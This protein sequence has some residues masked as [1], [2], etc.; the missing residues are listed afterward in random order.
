M[1]LA[2]VELYYTV[3]SLEVVSQKPTLCPFLKITQYCVGFADR[4]QLIATLYGG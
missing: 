1:I 4:I 2:E 3:L